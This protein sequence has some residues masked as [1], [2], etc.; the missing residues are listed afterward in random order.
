MVPFKIENVTHRLGH[1]IEERIIRDEIKMIKQV[2]FS[3]VG[4]RRYGVYLD[5][6]RDALKYTE[7]KR[8]PALFEVHVHDKIYLLNAESKTLN[9]WVDL[10]Q[11]TPFACRKYKGMA[12]VT[13]LWK[14]HK[15]ALNERILRDYWRGT[16]IIDNPELVIVKNGSRKLVVDIP[17]KSSFRKFYSIVNHPDVDQDIWIKVQDLRKIHSVHK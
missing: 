8:I 13:A 12:I 16:S 4:S 9:G 15:D 6:F 11:T 5:G 17:K 2:C 10:F 1:F 3:I 14:A 7:S